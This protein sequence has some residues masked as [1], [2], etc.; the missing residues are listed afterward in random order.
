M[1]VYPLMYL[2]YPNKNEKLIFV[3]CIFQTLSTR[4]SFTK[5][6]SFCGVNIHVVKRKL[7]L[8]KLAYR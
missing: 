5:I 2:M 3:I 7:I 8:A 1:A 6:I 4:V